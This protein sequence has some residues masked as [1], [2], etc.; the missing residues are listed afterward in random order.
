LSADEITAQQELATARAK[1]S[2]AKMT[3][4]NA[5]SRGKVLTALMKE[6]QSGRI[7]GI[8]VRCFQNTITI[9]N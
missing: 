8:C 3:L 7:K 2:D 6:K 1:T 9:L 4:Q 5:Q